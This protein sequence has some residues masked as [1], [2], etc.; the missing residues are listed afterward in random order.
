MSV[1]MRGEISVFLIATAVSTNPIFAPCWGGI[2]LGS[3]VLHGICLRCDS[4]G[5]RISLCVSL[6]AEWQCTLAIGA[7]SWAFR[8]T[9]WFLTCRLCKLAPSTSSWWNTITSFSGGC[10]L[11]KIVFIIIWLVVFIHLI[12]DLLTDDEVVNNCLKW[13][14]TLDHVD[15]KHSL[16]ESV[17]L[18]NIVFE[19]LVAT[20]NSQ[21]KLT[22]LDLAGYS[23]GTNQIKLIFYWHNGDSDIQLFH[24]HI[25]HFVHFIVLSRSENNRCFFKQFITLFIK[26]FLRNAE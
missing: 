17:V 7:S 21:N 22:V 13:L 3:N 10:F 9:Y 18:R 19:F 15:Y 2:V 1:C 24:V 23:V 20:S 26:F 11:S 5:H 16:E 4:L 12:F 14:T 6:S 25:N 8:S